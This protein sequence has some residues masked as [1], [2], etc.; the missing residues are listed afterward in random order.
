MRA[1]LVSGIVALMSGAVVSADQS[2]AKPQA[3]PQFGALRPAQSADP[4]R[5]L[6]DVH[7]KLFDVREPSAA[8]P[9]P[10]PDSSPRPKVVC[11]MTMIPADPN[12][13]PKMPAA[14]RSDGTNYTIRAVEPPICWSPTP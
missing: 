13:D 9:K 8:V 3:T 5:K 12:I 1:F 6:F 4:Y 10:A 14:P 2:P 11:G 7:R